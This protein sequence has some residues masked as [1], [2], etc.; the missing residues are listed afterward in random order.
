MGEKFV[1]REKNYDKISGNSHYLGSAR[2][3]QVA[4]LRTRVPHFAT[5]KFLV[6]GISEMGDRRTERGLLYGSIRKY[7]TE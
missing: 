4:P 1:F 2:A 7:E 6:F 3:V 5:A